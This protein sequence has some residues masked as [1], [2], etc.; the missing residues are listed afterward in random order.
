MC[1]LAALCVML[2]CVD[3]VDEKQQ[4]KHGGSSEFT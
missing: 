4:D 1:S 2:C 3:F